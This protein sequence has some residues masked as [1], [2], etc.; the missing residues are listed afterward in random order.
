MPREDEHGEQGE[1]HVAA[2]LGQVRLE[3]S[4]QGMEGRAAGERRF[5]RRHERQQILAD[6]AG[7]RRPDRACGHADE[8]VP[9]VRREHGPD[10]RIAERGPDRGAAQ[11]PS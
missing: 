10:R 7:Q 11:L 3:V 4:G 9:K 5:T 6:P 2:V 1:A 8:D